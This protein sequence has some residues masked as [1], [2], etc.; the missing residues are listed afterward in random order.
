MFRFFLISLLFLN[1]YIY[2]EEKVEKTFPLSSAEEIASMNFSNQHYIG[3]CVNPLT[4]HLYLKN[5]DMVAKGNQ[6]IPVTRYFI[7]GSGIDRYFSNDYDNTIAAYDEHYNNYRGWKVFPETYLLGGYYEIAPFKVSLSNGIILEFYCRGN[8]SLLQMQKYG[9]SNYSNNSVSGKYD[10]RNI[11]IQRPDLNHINIYMP[12]GTQYNYQNPCSDLY[13]FFLLQKKKLPNGRVLKYYYQEGFLK[14]IEALD[15]QEKFVYTYLNFSRDY[16]SIRIETPT[17]KSVVYGYQVKPEFIEEKKKSHSRGDTC[18]TLPLMHFSDNPSFYFTK[19]Q[20]GIRFLLENVYGKNESFHC[21]YSSVNNYYRVN[22]LNINSGEDGNYH[23]VYTFSYDLPKAGLS[24]GSTTV[25]KSDGSFTKYYFNKNILL[26]GV[27]E[28]DKNKNCQKKTQYAWTDNQWLE[29]IELFDGATSVHKTSYQYDEFGN[30]TQESFTGHLTDEKDI[31]SYTIKKEFSKDGFNL[32]LKEENDDGLII[33]YQYLPNTNLL[34]C[35]MQSQKDL[36]N[37]TA[38][39][40][41]REFYTYDDSNNLIQKIIDDGITQDKNDLTDVSERKITNY[42]LRQS[43]PYLHMVEWVEEKYLDN[44]EEKLLKKTH[45]LY[46]KEGYVCQ[47][48]TYDSEAKLSYTTYKT[49]NSRGDLLY[50]KNPLGHEINYTYTPLGQL[51]TQDSF[52]KKLTTRFIYDARGR[53]IKE[54]EKA[55][56]KI[57]HEKNY[58]YDPLDHLIKHE[59]FLKNPTQYEYDGIHATPSKTLHPSRSNLLKGPVSVQTF[60]I[61]NALDKEIYKFD[62]NGN[63]TYYKYNAYGSPLEILYGDQTKEAYT[64]YNNGNLHTHTDPDGIKIEYFY[65]IQNRVIEKK[66]YSAKEEFL[67]KEDFTY[68]TFHLLSETNREGLITSYKHDKAGRK[69]LEKTADHETQYSYDSLGRVN[70]IN[71]NDLLFINYTYDLLDRVTEENRTDALEVLYQI[72]YTYDADG[73]RTSITKNVHDKKASSQYVYDGFKRLISYTDPLGYLTTTSYEENT[74]NSLNQKVLKIITCDPKG[75]TRE[76]TYDA[77]SCVVNEEVKNANQKTLSLKEWDYDAHGNK[78]QER[79]HIYENETFIKRF[80]TDYSYNNR[81]LLTRLSKA[82][83]SEKPRTTCYRY[84]PS[85]LI[86]E[87]IL[88]SKVSLYYH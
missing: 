26:T 21:D 82:S 59:D 12:D 78:L 27:E 23:E 45:Y 57:V 46:D 31:Q 65:D 83:D 14:R 9:I 62:A 7:E 2:S 58:H 36:I 55:Q 84:T 15:S 1:S 41:Y 49:Y 87:K 50:E 5:I 38:K 37:K 67:A 33:E 47:E 22:K 39:I 8:D 44:N 75:I 20:Y 40:F 64:Y 17:G 68:N 30:P 18:Q 54:I 61:L 53:R 73:N 56:D 66:Y 35:K 29:S 79:D 52:S 77:L 76:K 74:S 32:L 85:G 16:S 24:D 48:E 25:N 80:I 28:F 71:K 86:Q 42:I 19:M 81:N 4:G 51:E 43:Q 6:E 10:I 34:L 70:K 11:K 63:A 72:A 88:P 69:F 3:N 13:N 60:S